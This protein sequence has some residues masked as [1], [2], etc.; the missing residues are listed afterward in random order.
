MRVPTSSPA[1]VFSRPQNVSGSPLNAV[2]EMAT[3][4]ASARSG[5]SRKKAQS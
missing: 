5:G 4:S 3:P 2:P 1:P